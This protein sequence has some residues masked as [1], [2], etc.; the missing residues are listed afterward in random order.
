VSPLSKGP[1]ATRSRRASYAPTA[2]GLEEAMI[3]LALRGRL[4]NET[5]SYLHGLDIET[6]R[7]RSRA[8]MLLRGTQRADERAK[9]IS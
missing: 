8:I 3:L 4:T 6:V 9:A 1:F 2:I 7:S 5:I